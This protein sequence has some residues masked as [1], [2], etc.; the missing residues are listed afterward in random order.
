MIIVRITKSNFSKHRMLSPSKAPFRNH[1][2][3]SLVIICPWP[4]VPLSLSLFFQSPL[5]SGLSICALSVLSVKAREQSVADTLI[6]F[7]EC[8][9]SISLLTHE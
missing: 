7:R 4:L 6:S 5:E 1:G 3:G 9:Y 8:M 2:E